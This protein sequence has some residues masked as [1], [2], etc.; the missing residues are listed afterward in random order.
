MIGPVPVQVPVVAL[1]CW[2]WVVV[3][4]IVG[5]WVLCGGF[6]VLAAPAETSETCESPPGYGEQGGG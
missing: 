1:S 3:P 6:A 2:P 4:L 5:G